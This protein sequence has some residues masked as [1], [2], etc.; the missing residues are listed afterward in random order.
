VVRYGETTYDGRPAACINWV[1]VGYFGEHADKLNSFQIVLVDRSD[2]GASGDF[3]IMLNYDRILWETGDS[4][5]GTN[6][7][8]G[9][10]AAAGY[11][12]GSGNPDHFFSFPGSL[13]NGGLL[14]SN[15]GTGLVNHNHNSSILGR[16]IFPVRSGQTSADAGGC[17]CI[18][19]GPNGPLIAFCGESACGEDYT[20]YACS[21]SGWSATGQP[22]SV[23]SDAGVTPDAAGPPDSGLCECVGTGP[24]GAPVVAACGGSAC[25]ED[26]TIYACDITG[27]APTGQPCS[28]PDAG[29]TPDAGGPPDSGI[30]ECVGT[31]LGGVPVVAACGGSACGDDFILYS[32]SAAGWSWIGQSCS[33]SSDAGTGTCQCTGSGPGGAP[34][35]V[36][37]GQ[38]TCGEDSTMYSCSASGWSPTGLPCACSCQGTGPGGFPVTVNCGQSACGEDFTSYS[39]TSSGWSWTGQACTCGCSGTGPGGVPISVNCGQ[40]ACGSDY[41]MY[42]CSNAGWS[43]TG[44][45][46]SGSSD[47][48]VLP[49]AGGPDGSVCQCLGTG[50]GE[51]PVVAACGQSA[52]GDDYITYS[53]S[54]AGWSWTGVP[55]I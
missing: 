49:D 8:G 51:V 50:P 53:C 15:A 6:G 54:A 25:G 44:Q 43:A 17:Q 12:D 4:G 14:D 18:G 33:G 11:S 47:A 10:S 41:N 23:P 30:C 26:Y 45:T 7:L 37:C 36:S 22:C 19:S 20:L 38:S 24:G 39:C 31:G 3:D 2:I 27:W 29:V 35:T 48:G 46:C 16:Y 1:D 21:S 42:S 55:C 13:V 40:S 28:M 52:C 5:G 32:C 34:V 9:T